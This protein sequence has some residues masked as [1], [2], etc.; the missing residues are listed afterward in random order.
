[1]TNKSEWQEANRRLLDEERRKLGDPPTAEEMLAY[2]RGEL[3]ESEEERIRE[4]LVAYPE[5]ARVYGA[6]IPEEPR[7]GDPDAVSEEEMRAGW[8]AL[9]QRLGGPARPAPRDDRDRRAEGQRG[10]LVIRHYIPTTIAAAFALVF[11]ALF[12]QAESRARHHERQGYLPRV[13]GEPQELEPGGRR[14][15][16]A[17]TML[18]LEGDGY[19]VRLR[20]FSGVQHPHYGVE[21]Q[22]PNG[23]ILWTNNTA[24][25]GEDDAFQV[26]IPRDFVRPGT[27][28]QLRVFS[29]DGDTR[30]ELAAYDVA[31]PAE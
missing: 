19:L 23:T 22:D 3:P 7:P 14:G 13:L 17:P 11:F 15:G 8:S 9:Q 10:R 31:V 12:V 18:R 26:F 25:P 1:M 2:C 28:Y 24:K 16:G 27:A 30:T 20:L 4:L 29:K 5:L 21:L 6:A